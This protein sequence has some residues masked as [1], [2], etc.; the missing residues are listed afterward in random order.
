MHIENLTLFNFKNYEDFDTQFSP[1]INCIAG[2]NGAGKTNLLDAIHYLCLTKSSLLST[3]SLLIRHGEG[4]FMVKGDFLK[5]DNKHT[6]HASLKTRQKKVIKCNDVHYEKIS[7]H[8]G[9]FPVVLISP[10]DTDLIREGSEIRRKFI[11]LIISQFDLQY[12]EGLMKYNHLIKQRNSLL[13]HFHETGSR[14][15]ELLDTYD[16]QIIP[17]CKNI[18]V[19]RKDFLSNFLHEFELAFKLISQG[20]ENVSLIY[21]SQLHN[22]NFE[23]RFKNAVEKDIILQRTTHGIHKDDLTFKIDDFPLKKFGSQGQQK[24]FVIALQLSKFRSIEKE[25]GFKPILLLDDIFDK[26]D[27][28]RIQSLIKMLED[29]EFGQVFITDARVERTKKLLETVESEIKILEI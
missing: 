1:Y 10:N 29:K 4:F 18:F 6:I 7:E 2:N 12:L 22:E 21:D 20:S 3:D 16:D 26:L 11:D 9:K 15:P 17:L 14:D 5:E 25:C 28:K 27:D 8:I 13:K 24:S 23:L 19:K